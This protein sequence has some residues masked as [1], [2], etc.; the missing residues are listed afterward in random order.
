LTENVT[1][2]A[3]TVIVDG[4]NAPSFT[5]T[6]T[7]E[8]VPYTVAP[9]VTAVPGEPVEP[10]EPQAAMAKLISPAKPSART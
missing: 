5:S 10:V 7:V 6:A 3:G 4:V 2:P 9:S 1:D 8:G